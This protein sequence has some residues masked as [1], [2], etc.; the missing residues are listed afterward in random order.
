MKKK[1]WNKA[2]RRYID[3]L[4]SPTS[5][6][7]PQNEVELVQELGCR[8][9]TLTRWRSIPGFQGA[10]DEAIQRRLLDRKAN[11]FE[12]VGSIAEKGDI[13][14]IKMALE[15]MGVYPPPKPTPPGRDPLPP[16]TAE[17][18]TKAIEDVAAWHEQ[19]FGNSSEEAG[20]LLEPTISQRPS[21]P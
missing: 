15:L 3:W 16:Y 10:V 11:I 8:P 6:R 12:V 1:K 19:Q 9:A 17:E 5:L 7:D 2:Q 13:R 20:Q 18:Y 21:L 14:H 4:S